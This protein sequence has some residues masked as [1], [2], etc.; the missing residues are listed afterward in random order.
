MYLLNN[1]VIE[2]VLTLIQ[3]ALQCLSKFVMA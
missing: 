1:E 2:V 3:Q